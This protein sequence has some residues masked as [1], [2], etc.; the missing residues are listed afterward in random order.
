VIPRQAL[1]GAEYEKQLATVEI[2]ALAAA[3]V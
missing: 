1:R 2:V 3:D